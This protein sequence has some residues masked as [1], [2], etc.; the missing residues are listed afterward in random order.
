MCDTLVATSEATRDG[1]VV[2]AKNSD[3]EPN[4]AQH[5]VYV[6]AKDF[7]A[8][9]QVRCTYIE[10]PQVEHTYALILSKPFW[11]WGAEMGVNE[12]NV[13]IG[14]EAVFTKEPYVKKD[15]GLIG[16]DLLRLGLERGRTA[17][18]ALRVILDL[19]AEFGQGGN[20][21]F[22]HKLYYHNSYLIADPREAWVL[23]TAGPH[24]AAKQVNGVYSISNGITI[25]GE[26][27]LA[28][29][30]LVANAVR[31]GWSK[32]DQ[33]FGFSRCYSDFLYTYFC[34]CRNRRMRT[35]DLLNS[36]VGEIT[37][38]T[39]MSILRDH[40]GE[41][42][43]WRPDTGVTGADVC[44][45]AGFGPIRVSQTV[46]SFVA[47]L[48]PEHPT[49][50]FTGTAAPCT[51]VFKPVWMDAG[52]PDLGPEPRGTFDV[53]TTFWRHESL[54]RATLRD[55]DNLIKIYDQDRK[56]L[57]NQFISTGLDLTEDSAEK[58][59]KYSERTFKETE[60]LESQWLEQIMRKSI[61]NRPGRLFTIAWNGFNRGA[62][63]P[64]FSE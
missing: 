4:E 18:E 35:M 16:M 34:D 62:K 1:V 28:S 11:I 55:Y 30:D 29:S 53:Q 15:D 8:G 38:E 10:I 40:G 57:E 45:H 36:Q 33:D 17:H 58:R 5:L 9:S 21:G 49:Y 3:R 64:A 39:A 6:P 52:L 59:L 32:S 13:V 43:L 42:G 44:M 60:I 31:K 37:V 46:G 26:Y 2:F 22:Q 47:H 51:S 12:H 41:N 20:C 56:N 48:H 23:E 14:N 7:P 63:M 19:L 61:Q 50:F 25:D 24:W 54:H 27:D